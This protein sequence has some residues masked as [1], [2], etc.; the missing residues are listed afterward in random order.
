MSLVYPAAAMVAFILLVGA[1]VFSVRVGHVR[2]GLV[3]VGYFRVYDNKGMDA[4][5]FLVRAGRHYDN[6]MQLPMLYFAT[7]AIAL[8]VKVDSPLIQISAWL[9]IVTR[10]VHSYIHLGSNHVMRRAQAFFA[11][12]FCII[13]MWIAILIG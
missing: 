7:I 3:K 11:G 10:A 1:F 2:K 12:W 5:E 13:A 4:P 8:A 9:F 6:L